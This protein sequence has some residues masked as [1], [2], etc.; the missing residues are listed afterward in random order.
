MKKLGLRAVLVILAGS[1]GSFGVAAIPAA[2]GSIA[3]APILGAPIVAAS[4]GTAPAVGDH[5]HSAWGVYVCD[6]FVKLPEPTGNDPV[7]I[8]THGDGLIHTHPFSEK[9]AGK[10][11]IMARFFET[12]NRPVFIV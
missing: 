6:K 12:E 3:A 5:W 11:A 10:I 2:S 7:G 1:V 8:H 4:K 9:A